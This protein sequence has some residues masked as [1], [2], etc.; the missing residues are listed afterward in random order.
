MIVAKFNGST[1]TTVYGL[2]R[3][4]YGQD[5]KIIA[6]MEI[7]DGTEIQFYQGDLDVLR[8]LHGGVV[9]IPDR[10][11]QDSD[12]ITVY[13][14]VRTDAVGET[15]LTVSLPVADRPRPSNYIMPDTEEHLRLLPAGG[16]KGQV[17]VKMPGDDYSVGWEN[18]A[19]GLGYDGEYLQLMSG[20]I[21][22]GDRVRIMGGSGREIEL[23]NDGTDIKWRYTDSNDWHILASLHDLVGPQG[24]PGETPEFELREGHLYAIYKK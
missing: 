14:Y 12:V 5:L 7:P 16:E 3:W 6:E 17:L 1:V 19:D 18:R 13:I 20:K 11:L 22:V 21:P 10:M 23:A 15:I 8:Y 2:T 4:D 9:R 24:L